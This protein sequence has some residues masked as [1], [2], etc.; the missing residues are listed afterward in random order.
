MK[1]SILICIVIFSFISCGEFLEEESRG[2][3]TLQNFWNTDAEVVSATTALYSLNNNTG[4]GISDRGVYGRGIHLYSLMPS[5]D[6]IVGKP[7]TQ[8]QQIKDFETTGS[9]GYTHDIWPL[10]FGII[11]RANDILLM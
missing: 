9:G 3:P 2:T 10:H 7:K 8:I 6:F 5:D 11:K 1:K 4:P